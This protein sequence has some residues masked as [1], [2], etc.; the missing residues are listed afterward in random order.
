GYK[1]FL[2][3]KS[4]IYIYIPNIVMNNLNEYILNNLEILI[5]LGFNGIL[6]GNIGYLE[7][8]LNLKNRY[9]IVIGIDYSLNVINCFSAIFYK[10]K[11]IDYITVSN[12]LDDI[13]DIS[14]VIDVECIDEFI[15]VMTTRLCLIKTYMNKC[16][17]D[18]FH[19]IFD[20]K[21]KEYHIICDKT[22]CINKLVTSYI[23]N[24]K[25][26]R[27]RKCVI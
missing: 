19:S 6:L 21:N 8:C 20:Y 17:C 22:D 26:N 13:T 12:E 14:K 4:K 9:N 2:N 25:C 18:N 7:L 10:E 24:V 23:N 15:T 3:L 16:D 5:S 1:Y 11:N 27:I